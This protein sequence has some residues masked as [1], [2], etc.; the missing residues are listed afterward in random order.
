MKNLPLTELIT[1]VSNHEEEAFNELY[2]RYYKL[3]RYIAFGLTKSDADTD[4][5]VQE[6]FIQV[7]KS[8]HD[9]NDPNLFKAWLSRITYS[10]AKML[11]RKHRD[12]S[13][14]ERCLE[15]LN[16]QEEEREEFVP[17]RKQ[18]HNHDLEVLYS[19]MQKLKPDFIEV[20]MF[21]YFSQMS[22]KEIAEML[23]IPEGTIKS[24][25]LYAKKYLKS[26]ILAYETQ[27]HERITFQGK[28][29]EAALF[30]IGARMVYEPTVPFLHF[31]RGHSTSLTMKA[32][33][34][35]TLSVTAVGGVHTVL[36]AQNER[37]A[38]AQVVKAQFQPVIYRGSW[39]NTPREAYIALIQWA[40]CE[41]EMRQKSNAE[42]Q[43]IMPVYQTL[44]TFG[45]GYS[46]LLGKYGW[47][48]Q[49]EHYQSQN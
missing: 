48:D 16:N 34:I 20:L 13:M 11:F 30:S 25:M 4:E 43:E 6:V 19:C 1:K 39:I 8:V 38:D 28:T 40:D 26:E 41:V 44:I 15:A 3:V 10:K 14:D 35:V 47:D 24:R 5:I 7:Q 32:V 27:T 22:I 9:L 21:Y 42:F 31:F 2:R 29:M 46:E 37:K 49:F 23:N 36:N 17:R 12:H 18:R 33:M 45:E